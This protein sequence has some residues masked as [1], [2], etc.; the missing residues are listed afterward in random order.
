MTMPYGETIMIVRKTA[1]GRDSYGNDTYTTSEFTVLG[2]VA[3]KVSSE[4]MQSRDQVD[5]GL[6]AWVPG[7][8]T[9]YATDQFLIRGATYEVDGD[10]MDWRSPF[11][12]RAAPVQI[13]LHK[14]TG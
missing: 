5:S 10:P 14:V 8:T 13:M 9:V 3:P 7:G 1:S 2:A 6:I 11:T 12:G 4:D